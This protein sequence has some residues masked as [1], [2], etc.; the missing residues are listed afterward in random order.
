MWNRGRDDR[1]H[2]GVI[3]GAS[4]GS[5]GTRRDGLGCGIA[6]VTTAPTMVCGFAGATVPVAMICGYRGSDGTRRDGLGCGIAAVT[7]APTMVCG[8][9]GATVPVA[10]DLW[11]SW[12]RWYPPRWFGMRNRGRDGRSYNGVIV[13]AS[14]GSGGPRRDDLWLSWERWYPPRWFGMWNAAVTAAPTTGLLL[15]LLVGAVVPAAMVW[16]A[17]SRSRRPLLQ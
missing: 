1:S 10:M 4:R 11:L 2:N 8:F 6:A 17:E 3:V 16:D 14:R 7:T 12:E 15:V 5:D 13:G 9:V